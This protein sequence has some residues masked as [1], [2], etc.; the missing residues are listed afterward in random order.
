MKLTVSFSNRFRSQNKT[1]RTRANSRVSVVTHISPNLVHL[2]SDN[3]ENNESS[4]G[5]TPAENIQPVSMNGS[6]I[7]N[8]R[9]IKSEY[10]SEMNNFVV[11][12]ETPTH[13]MDM[14][15][16]YFVSI[17]NC[18]Q[19]FFIGFNCCDTRIETS[20]RDAGHC[21]IVDQ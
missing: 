11:V 1:Q 18:L 13:F 3:F 16:K 6:S 20:H 15:C 17:F 21:V 7:G 2:F 4:F 8:I 19:I 12:N 5:Q 9:Y 10:P 14:L